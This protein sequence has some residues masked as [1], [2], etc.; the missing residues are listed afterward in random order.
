MIFAAFAI[1]CTF[2]AGG[3][4]TPTPSPVQSASPTPVPQPWPP[5]PQT[6]KELKLGTNE[7]EAAST[8]KPRDLSDVAA[9]V[10]LSHPAGVPIVIIGRPKPPDLRSFGDLPEPNLGATPEGARRLAAK[11]ALAGELAALGPKTSDFNATMRA[12]Y[13]ACQGK[14]TEKVTTEA[15]AGVAAGADATAAAAAAAG[16]RGGAVAAGVSYGEWGA[17]WVQRTVRSESLA[18]ETTVECRT[19]QSRSQS[20]LGELTTA[21]DDALRRARAAGALPGDEREVLNGYG[22]NW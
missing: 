4:A 10:R 15:R 9:G 5:R 17:A 8:A 13:D 14:Y 7:P 16:P 22:L 21:R 11:R 20:L 2:M 3:Q 18:N 1:A 12:Y 6:V 19:L